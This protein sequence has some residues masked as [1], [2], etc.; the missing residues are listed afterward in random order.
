MD[1]HDHPDIIWV[2]IPSKLDNVEVE[3]QIGKLEAYLRRPRPYVLLFKIGEGLPD[4]AQRKMLTDHMQQNTAII[5]RKVK[6]LGVVVPSA[7]ARGMMTAILWFAPP[8]IP[9]RLFSSAS[10]AEAW[11]ATLRSSAMSARL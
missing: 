1:A 3:R 4:A 9:H 5:E 10:D 8:K 6:G 7:L 11:A 2:T